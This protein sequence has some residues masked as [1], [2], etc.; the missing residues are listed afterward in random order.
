MCHQISDVK[1]PENVFSQSA[2][3]GDR[4]GSKSNQ[5]SFGYFIREISASL[6][7]SVAKTV[8]LK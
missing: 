5:S 8:C 3:C 2:S 4:R 6:F 1:D 7:L